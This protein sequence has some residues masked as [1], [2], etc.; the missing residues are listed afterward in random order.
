MVNDAPPGVESQPLQASARTGVTIDHLKEQY[1]LELLRAIQANKRYPKQAKR[2]RQQGMVKV[3]FTLQ[4]N[5]KIIN[6]RIIQSSGYKRLDQSAKTA[7]LE[8]GQFKPVPEQIYRDKWEFVVPI[9]Y[10]IL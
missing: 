3:G 6:V 8:I 5:G 7:V 4:G 10:Q 1:K 2:R 9:D